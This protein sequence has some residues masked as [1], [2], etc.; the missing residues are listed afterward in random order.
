MVKKINTEQ[1]LKKSR[2]SMVCYSANPNFH[3][4]HEIKFPSYYL[5][6]KLEKHFKGQETIVPMDKSVCVGW[7]IFQYHN[8]LFTQIKSEII[9]LE[10]RNFPDQ[11]WDSLAQRLAEMVRVLG[12][13]TSHIKARFYE[14]PLGVIT[15]QANK[16]SSISSR[17][18]I[19]KSAISLFYDLSNHLK[20][21]DTKIPIL[22]GLITWEHL[23]RNNSKISHLSTEG[24]SEN[25]LNR[26]A[27]RFT[28]IVNENHKFISHNTPKSF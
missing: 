13:P 19:K 8:P 7:K 26:I 23:K 3:V 4:L 5:F 6:E 20:K 1:S 24:L 25:Y 2:K 11:D 21:N 15:Y 10:G 22:H 9:A 27:V 17:F 18:V 12:S 16:N 28:K 14:K